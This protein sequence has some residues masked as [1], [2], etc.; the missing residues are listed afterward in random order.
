M[1][2]K[3]QKAEDLLKTIQLQNQHIRQVCMH[4][5]T[6][7]TWASKAI[8]IPYHMLHSTLSMHGVLLTPNCSL[9]LIQA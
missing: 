6:R 2:D 5:V 9:L 3:C 7:G 4:D 8:I 1:E